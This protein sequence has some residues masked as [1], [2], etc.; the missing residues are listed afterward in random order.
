MRVGDKV[1]VRIAHMYAEGVI[2]K[3]KPDCYVVKVGEKD[4]D[5]PKSDCTSVAALE[6]WGNE[7]TTR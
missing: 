3:I 7:P 6:S 1:F 2:V 4:F 5:I